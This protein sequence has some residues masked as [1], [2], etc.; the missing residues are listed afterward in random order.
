[1]ET[2]FSSVSMDT[3]LSLAKLIQAKLTEFVT[4]AEQDLE[5]VSYSSEQAFRDEYDMFIPIS[6][7][8]SYTTSTLNI[9][10]SWNYLNNVV[11]DLKSFDNFHKNILRKNKPLCIKLQSIMT[12]IYDYLYSG[13]EVKED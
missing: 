3:S 8:K 10:N 4:L 13:I 2:K 5:L 11:E 12:E 6:S 1:M 7:I 9:D